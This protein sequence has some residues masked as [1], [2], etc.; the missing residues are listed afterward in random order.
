ML[1]SD[2]IAL[3]IPTFCCTERKIPCTATAYYMTSIVLATLSARVSFAKPEDTEI[4]DAGSVAGADVGAD[5]ETEVG[6]NVE[7]MGEGSEDGIEEDIEED[8]EGEMEADIEERSQVSWAYLDVP[9]PSEAARLELGSQ[10]SEN[11]EDAD[12]KF[13]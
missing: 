3:S 4:E 5:D 2:Y 1:G 10:Y 11:Y 8:V 6:E 7:G 13:W 9:T 12:L